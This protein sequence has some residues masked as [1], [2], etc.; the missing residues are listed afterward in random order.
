MKRPLWS[1]VC[2]S[3]HRAQGT[4]LLCTT[5]ELAT[6]QKEDIGLRSRSLGC[7]SRCLER[8]QYL[9]NRNTKLQTPRS[10]RAKSTYNA[11]CASVMPSISPRKGT[12][13]FTG[14]AVGS[15][16]RRGQW[17]LGSG[18]LE[19][20]AD[21]AVQRWHSIPLI[22]IHNKRSPLCYQ[23]GFPSLLCWFCVCI[24][25]DVH[26]GAKNNFQEVS[27]SNLGFQYRTQ[28]I[29]LLPTDP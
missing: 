15:A 26:V 10:S 6:P 27:L 4:G 13:V 11:V 2:A 16:S 3:R 22:N 7:V 21:P 12:S 8:L 14:L 9:Y 29:V 25:H 5:E 24:Y 20:P 23:R 1:G 18:I 17:S 28:A 19:S